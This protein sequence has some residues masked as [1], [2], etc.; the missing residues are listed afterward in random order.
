[1]IFNEIYLSLC[2]F[3]WIHLQCSS[4]QM[5]PNLRNKVIKKTNQKVKVMILDGTTTHSRTR[6]LHAYYLYV[7]LNQ[8]TV[9]YSLLLRSAQQRPLYDNELLHFQDR[10]K[11]CCTPLLSSSLPLSTPL[12]LDGPPTYPRRPGRNPSMA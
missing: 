9:I 5:Y 2:L 12:H 3:C 10:W 1:M 7:P 8:Q 4:L 6:C 11:M